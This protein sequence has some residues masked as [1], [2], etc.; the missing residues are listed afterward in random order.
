MHGHG[1]TRVRTAVVALAVVT[2]GAGFAV[3]P[4]GQLLVVERI[5]TGERLLAVPVEDG[6][7]VGLEYTHSVEKTRVYDGYTVRDGRLVMTR[8]EFESYGW[9]L[10]ARANVTR[11]NGTF[12]YDPPGNVSE[13][14]VKPGRIANHT[15]HVD[16]RS[17]DLVDLADAESV[18]IH[19]RSRSVFDRLGDPD[20]R[21]SPSPLARNHV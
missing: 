7:Q 11:E 9:G 2:V 17:Y 1:W 13:L 14:A 19:L 10:P 16:D 5:D 4:S 15:L 8:M 12:V 6:T 20:V 3:A 18:R 21:A